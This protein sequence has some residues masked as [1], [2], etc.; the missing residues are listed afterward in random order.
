M[1]KNKPYGDDYIPSD[2]AADT[3]DA[4]EE[5]LDDEDGD[6]EDADLDD[7]DEDDD[8]EEELE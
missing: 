4:Q 2:D 6:E 7:S 3:V 8:E 1:K 5:E